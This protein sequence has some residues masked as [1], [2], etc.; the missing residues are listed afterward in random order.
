MAGA[1]RMGGGLLAL[2]LLVGGA[3]AQESQEYVRAKTGAVLRNFQDPQGNEILRPAAGALLRVHEK[4][5]LSDADGREVIWLKVS[6]PAGLPVWVYGK[7]L[8][9]TSVEGVLRVNANAVRMRPLPSSSVSSFPIGAK[10]FR[11][12]RVQFIERNDASAVWAEDWARVWSP[13]SAMVWVNAAHT[14]PETDHSAANAEWQSSLRMLPV[15]VVASTPKAS[16]GSGPGALGHADPAD[17]AA[18]VSNA[19]EVVPA[20]AS[21]RRPVPE[22]AYK[23][24]AFGNTLLNGALELGEAALESSFDPAIRAYEIVLD[25]APAGSAVAANA[26]R[27]LMTAEAH[28]TAA[29]VRTG[30]VAAEARRLR[31]RETLQAEQDRVA[32][33]GT[34]HWGRF[35]GRGWLESK[36]V[37][38]QT[39]WSLKW[40]GEVRFEIECRSGRYDLALFEGFEL[41]VKGSTIRGQSMATEEQ[42][43]LVA[44]LDVTRLEVISAGV[45]RR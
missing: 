6:A 38:R 9:Q 43:A 22:E 31:E 42:R 36:T 28:A 21:A 37:G 4:S 14:T 32:M 41:G 44:L 11:G 13:A 10:L 2:A 33:A 1:R 12:D 40:G 5:R 17:E 34:A 27:Q 8:E 29:A 39:A 3:A 35:S 19:Q 45:R 18:T 25:M 15:P 16:T 23:S 26:G 24:L 7:F 30:I 20:Q